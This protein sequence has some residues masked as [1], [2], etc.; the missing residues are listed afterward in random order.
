MTEHHKRGR[1]SMTELDEATSGLVPRRFKPKRFVCPRCG[2]NA[3]K[4]DAL[5]QTC[6]AEEADA[7]DWRAMQE[8]LRR[9]G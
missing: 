1:V 4:E 9:G 3:A 2:W 8:D 5:C 6:A 7:A